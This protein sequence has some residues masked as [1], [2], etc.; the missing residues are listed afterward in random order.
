MGV[1][2]PVSFTR[3]D[4]P[5]CR[6]CGLEVLPKETHSLIFLSPNARP[7]QLSPYCAKCK[8]YY[9]E[10]FHRTLTPEEEVAH[11]PEEERDAVLAEHAFKKAAHGPETVIIRK[12][13]DGQDVQEQGQAG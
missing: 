6:K 7:V 9:T 2:N 10:P 13:E 8:E 5:R 12:D 3:R 1:T 11:L 4:L